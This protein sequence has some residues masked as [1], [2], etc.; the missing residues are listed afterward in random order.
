MYNSKIEHLAWDSAFFNRKIGKISEA[1]TADLGE[2][3]DCAREQNYELVYV[4]GASDYFPEDRIL[5]QFAGQLVD[6]KVLYEKRLTNILPISDEIQK[7]DGT[8]LT[9][10]LEQLAYIS[11][12]FSRFRMEKYFAEQDFERMYKMWIEK[13]LTK[14]MAD[15][16]FVALQNG[17]VKGMVTL[18]INDEIGHIGLIS[19]APDAQ[20]NGYGRKLLNACENELLAKNASLLAVPTQLDNISA[21]RFYE[22]CGFTVKSITNIYHFNTNSMNKY[23]KMLMGGG[24]TSS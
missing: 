22:K 13:S 14:E 16:V 3:L 24:I 18:K 10:E 7:Y 1:Q 19:V 20:K 23:E 12:A 21:C 17:R 6:R 9:P 2:L 4:F 11:G 5:V 8:E 15:D